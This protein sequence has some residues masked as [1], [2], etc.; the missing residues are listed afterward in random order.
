MKTDKIN[1]GDW[2]S[3]AGEGF[4]IVTKLHPFYWDMFC[5]EIYDGENKEDYMDIHDDEDPP[6]FGGLCTIIVQCRR[7]CNYDGTPIRSHKMRSC[8]IDYAEKANDKDMAIINKA[9]QQY[10]KEYTSF[11]KFDKSLD[12]RFEIHY[13][14]E[15]EE[16]AKLAAYLF[17]N[18]IP[19]QLPDKFTSTQLKEVMDLNNCPFKLDEPII[20]GRTQYPTSKKLVELIFHYN[21]GDYKGKETLYNRVNLWYYGMTK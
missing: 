1:I 16:C 10:P 6:T 11:L 14:V 8:Q 19:T 17:R 21:I 4:G 13:W 12:Y 5:P 7:F 3:C 2:I 15:N 18:K 20:R 9:I